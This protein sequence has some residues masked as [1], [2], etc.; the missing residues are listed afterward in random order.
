[1]RFP[2]RFTR[3]VGAPPP[4]GV[5]LGSDAVPSAAEDRARDVAIAIKPFSTQGVPL[6]TLL[7]GY[8]GPVGAL[9]LPCRVYVWEETLGAW[10]AFGP[11]K[12]IAPG[13]VSTF[14]LPVPME[15]PDGARTGA[16]DCVVVISSVGGLPAGA[17]E[18]VLVGDVSI[19][20]DLS[21][22][23]AGPLAVTQGTVPW[24]VSQSSVPWAVCDKCGKLVPFEFDF[25]DCGYTA[26]KL[27][28][29][30]YKTG[31]AGGTTVA[32]LAITYTGND[33]DTVTRT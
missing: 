3:Y 23:I 10:L 16:V 6:Q 33:I 17:Y 11:S 29:V 31:G 13:E 20:A 4:G 8:R 25:I 26:G 18:F 5:A 32:T 9:A 2:R 12:N 21:T 28:S 22:T 19:D 27:T 30:I 1:M 24:V 15:E 14:N 7:V